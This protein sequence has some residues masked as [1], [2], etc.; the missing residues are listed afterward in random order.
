MIRCFLNIL[1]KPIGCLISLVVTL[2]IISVIALA[3]GVWGAGKWGP[4][5]AAK[6]I[7][8]RTD[9]P[10][11]I[12][13]HDVN[14]FVGRVKLYNIRIHN[15]TDFR[16]PEMFI[17]KEI[18]ISASPTKL[19]G[20]KKVI[21]QIVIDIEKIAVVIS[22]D[23]Q[24]NVNTFA[25]ALAGEKDK[26]DDKEK[27]DDRKEPEAKQEHDYLIRELVFRIGTVTY[28]DLSRNSPLE[29]DYELNYSRTF[30][31][32]SDVTTQVVQPLVRD[33]GAKGANFLVA[34]VVTSMLEFDTY[35]EAAEELINTNK[36]L[37]DSGSKLIENTGSILDEA[38]RTI[39]GLFD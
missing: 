24:T 4:D 25:E 5:V 31:D 34:S 19:I 29:R 36:D 15:S 16:Y 3:I 6:T 33:L 30:K 23:H 17:A 38:S 39:K 10:T 22:E 14:L 35:S 20:E 12:G 37:I 8:V 7:S 26:D 1:F 21:D 28:E 32:V 18:S 2:L 13:S 11:S 27:S 9:F